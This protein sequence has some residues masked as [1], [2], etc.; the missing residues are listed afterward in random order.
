MIE[1]ELAFAD[2]SDNMD[3]IE[4]MVKYC[5]GYVLEH[6]PEEMAFFEKNI[7]KGCIERIR[8]VQ[9]SHF[10]R[11]TYT[12]AISHLEKAKDRFENKDIRWG[13]DLQSEHERY[14]CEEVVQGPV[15]LTD[16]PKEIKA[17]YMRENEDGKTVAACDLLVPEVGELVG[18]SQREERYDVL[19]GKMEALGMEPESLDWY[20]D[21]RRYGGCVH[22]GFGLGFDRMLMYFSGVSNIR[23][24]QPYPRTPRNLID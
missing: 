21:L 5:I 8:K 14:L 12:E 18:G 6:A 1:P 23:D 19:K 24:V 10:K 3:V 2:L 16:Y 13:M 9:D 22:S 15:F 11:M 7:D 4:D 17:F 20:L